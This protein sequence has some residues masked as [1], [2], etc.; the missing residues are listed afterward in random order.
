MAGNAVLKSFEVS[1]DLK[2]ST[3]N[4]P[5]EVVEGDT[6]NRLVITVTDN[7]VAVPCASMIV[8]AVFSNSNGTAVQDSSKEDGGISITDNVVTI[9]LFPASFAP[10]M[11]ECE[12]QLYS[13]SDGSGETVDFHTLVTTAK[14]NF[15]CRRAI[16]NDDT[17]ETV[18]EFPMLMELIYTVN[19]AEAARAAAESGR[20]EAEAVRDAAEN[21]RVIAENTRKI[22]EAARVAAEEERAAAEAIR[23]AAELER[24]ANIAEFEETIGDKL[25]ATGTTDPD[26]STEGGVGRRY[27]NIASGEAFV[28][29]PSVDGKM[30]S[31]LTWVKL[32]RSDGNGS[33]VTAIRN[34][35]Y[36]FMDIP[37]QEEVTLEKLLAILGGWYMQINANIR[38]IG[39]LS[40]NKLGINGDGSNVTVIP[41]NTIAKFD[42]FSLDEAIA[43]Q[44]MLSRLNAWYDAIVANTDS[45]DDLAADKLDTNGDGSAV[46]ATPTGATQKFTD[47][48]LG[49]RI[50][51]A[52][53]LARLN[54]WYAAINTI[55]DGMNELGDLVDNKLDKNGDGSSVIV[56]PTSNTAV[57]FENFT[58]GEAITLHDVLVKLTAW[59]DKINAI[60]SG[61]TTGDIEELLANKLD[62][63]GDGSQVTAT[64]TM[65]YNFSD[66]P[67][68]EAVS[69]EELLARLGGWYVQ[70]NTNIDGIKNKLDS[71]G[72]GSNITAKRSLTYKFNDIPMNTS[73]TF[74]ELLGRLGGWYTEVN[75][76]IT[77]PVT[78]GIGQILAASAVDDEG[79]PTEWMAVDMPNGGSAGDTWETIA[80]GELTEE[81]TAITIDKDN[82]GNSFELKEARLSLWLAASENNSGTGELRLRTNTDTAALGSNFSIAGGMKMADHA[83]LYEITGQDYLFLKATHNVSAYVMNGVNPNYRTL[84][85]L[86]LAGTTSACAN[87]GVGTK[88]TLMGVRA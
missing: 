81:V 26:T 37:V 28:A 77:A 48:T 51:L 53:T 82:D 73:V 66:I 65:S 25:Y 20:V 54:T 55:D 67:T 46:T 3:S 47:F 50:T 19:E 70:I 87:M 58:L 63:D 60:Y 34:M 62:V 32:L 21:S 33:N 52:D 68:G 64:R 69:L 2:R 88:W 45:V 76:K 17:I 83:I 10:G 75:N 27:V 71:N 84:T 79:K 41:E 74:A 59:Y 14:F 72:D 85:A 57:A 5:F 42:K 56:T 31:D 23:A 16:L 15:A 4:R 44:N 8:L 13:A 29:M 61:G 35:S 1:L 40:V 80:T 9:E 22:A 36:N 39:D 30:D 86:F 7:G 43:L 11:V 24:E 12:L 38:D 18:P 6:G 49:E 78:A